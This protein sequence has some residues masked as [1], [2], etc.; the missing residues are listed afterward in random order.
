MRSV[1]NTAYLGTGGF[2]GKIQYGSLGEA[3]NP[4]GLL[5]TQVIPQK[6]ESN[7]LWWST[8][9]TPRL[10]TTQHQQD[11]KSLHQFMGLWKRNLETNSKPIAHDTIRRGIHPGDALSPL[12]FC[13]GLNLLSHL[14]K[15]WLRVPVLKWSN[16][17]PP[18]L[19]WRHQA[20]CQEWA[21]HRL[22]DP[23]HQDL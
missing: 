23:H 8:K 1:G 9:Y 12:L 3:L 13:I 15:K 2:T 10:E 4:T 19:R 6:G 11:T 18:S 17:Q 5:L 7:K 14:H 22:A 21:R 16:H 20:V